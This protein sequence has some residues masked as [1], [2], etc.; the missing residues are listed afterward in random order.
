M[1]QALKILSLC[2]LLCGCD[3]VAKLFAEEPT[4]D[5]QAR[6]LIE[7]GHNAVEAENFEVAIQLFEQAAGL[8]L[9]DPEP[10]L[11][12]GRLHARMGNDGPAILALRRAAEL[13][14][15]DPEV[16]SLLADIYLRQGNFEAAIDH[17][18]KAAEAS[19][20]T[21]DGALMRKLATALLR[22]GEVDEAEAIVE[23]V[24]SASPGDPETLALFAEILI[25]TGDEERAVRLLDVAVA[26]NSDSARVRTVR[27]KYFYSR[28]KV[29]AA[30]REFE[31][32]ARAEPDN[33]AVATGRARA[34]ATARRFEEA[35]KVMEEV[36]ASRPTDMNAL[37]ALAEIHLMAG[38]GLAAQRVAEQVI[39]RQPLNGR[40]LYVRARAIEDQSS[41]DP[42]RAINAY[43]QV[44]DAEASQVEALSRLWRLHA[45]IGEKAN[46]M[47]TLEHLLLLGEASAEEE[48]ELAALYAETGINVT[49]GLK[50]IGAALGRESGNP[51]YLGIKRALEAKA[52][53]RPSRGGSGG[54][55]GIQVIRGGR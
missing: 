25:A 41:E 38:D 33:V 52:R 2:A 36:V 16:R 5:E 46:A 28:G 9:S 51:R 31:V 8:T 45:K 29:E 39:A 55:S 1:R 13:L 37:A 30:L 24:D 54:G 7:R 14:P 44:L 12:L 32:A 20:G 15:A 23:R 22:T 17:L 27:A 42:V 18:R 43:R 49:R 50:L 3:R 10:Q 6:A 26:A 4:R 53:E 40:A 21:P 47:S 48:V 34:L 19:E 35:T 11:A